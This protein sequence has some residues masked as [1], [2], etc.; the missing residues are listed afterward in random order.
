MDAPDHD[1][2]VG[3][4]GVAVTILFGLL[5]FASK[6]LRETKAD[7][8]KRIDEMREEY[9]QAIE[10]RATEGRVDRDAIWSQLRAHQVDD[11]RMHRELL[12]R[13]GQ[14]ATRE[15]LY[16]ATNDLKQDLQKIFQQG[17][18]REQKMLTN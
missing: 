17:H 6:S 3:S 9:G 8:N 10:K 1:I 2:V 5:G 12:D 11:E 4:L 14:M 15:D 7:L 13:L 18:S 16:R